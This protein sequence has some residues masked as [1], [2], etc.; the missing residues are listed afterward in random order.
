M[1]LSNSR[2]ISTAWMRKVYCFVIGQRKNQK[3]WLF[4]ETCQSRSLKLSANYNNWQCLFGIPKYF[5]KLGLS[6]K[7][8]VWDKMP[9][10]A[11]QC[12]AVCYQADVTDWWK[13]KDDILYVKIKYGFFTRKFFILKFYIIVY[14]K[15]SKNRVITLLCMNWSDH[16]VN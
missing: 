8:E 4:Y 10:I 6:M 1:L 7:W 11:I 14:F 13:T 15:R 2:T 9:N 3:S 5:I 16:N 12:W